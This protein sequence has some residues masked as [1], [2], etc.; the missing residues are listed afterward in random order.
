MAIAVCTKQ[1]LN[2]LGG[3][4]G[5]GNPFKDGYQ[6]FG[7]KENGNERVGAMVADK[8]KRA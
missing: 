6:R 4:F 1:S 8:I 2:I 3:A 5:F 7:G